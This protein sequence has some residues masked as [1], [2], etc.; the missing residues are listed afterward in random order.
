[1]HNIEEIY[2]NSPLIEVICE[3]R[4]QRNL[5][6][7][8]QRHGFYGKISKKYPHI[9]VPD[10]S[11]TTPSALIPY[12]FEP[13]NRNCGVKL[14]IDKFSYYDKKY[15]GHKKFIKEFTRLFDLFSKTYLI[16]KPTRVGWRYINVIPFI[17]DS[18]LIPLYDF[19]D[20]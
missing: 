5:K 11:P 19:F 17:R 14:A 8:C 16:N 1:M 6:I 9:L 12:K 13:E 15:E 3:L 18:G 7:E 10:F 2:P 4:F 20:I